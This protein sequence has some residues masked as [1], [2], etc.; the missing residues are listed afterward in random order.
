LSIVGNSAPLQSFVL[1]DAWP[2]AGGRGNEGGTGA[3]RRDP[4]QLE[5]SFGSVRPASTGA[6]TRRPKELKLPSIAQHWERLAAEGGRRRLP[7]AEYLAELRHHEACDRRERPVRRRIGDARSPRLK[8][9]EGLDFE[10]QPRLDRED[11]LEL[12]EADFVAERANVVL[13]G[14][15]GTGKTHLAIA[16]GMA[17]CQRGKRV[18]F[19]T[20]AQL[21]NLLVE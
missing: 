14:E 19:K 7:H 1:G 17:C 21:M 4:G 13:M 16:L 10:A 9:L 8:T 20:A 6:H 12:A 15:V 3:L 18:R 5:A 2:R 11:V